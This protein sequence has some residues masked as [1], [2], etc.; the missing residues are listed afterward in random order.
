[1]IAVISIAPYLT[2]KAE[3]TVPCKIRKRVHVKKSAQKE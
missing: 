1:M 3:H 2:D